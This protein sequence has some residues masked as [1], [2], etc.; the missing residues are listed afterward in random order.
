MDR[1]WLTKFRTKSAMTHDD[2]ASMVG[3]SRQYYGMIESGVRN[4]SVELAKRIAKIL[5]F[6]W[7]LFFVD[8]GN[9]LLLDESVN[10]EVI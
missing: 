1:D 5:K 4:P 6:N 2:V 3:V 10:K 9:E 7:T 8:E